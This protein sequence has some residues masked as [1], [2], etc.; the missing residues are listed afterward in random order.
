MT[1]PDAKLDPG[2]ESFTYSLNLLP[3]GSGVSKGAS[4]CNILSNTY[5]VA[6]VI[7]L[8]KPSG[9]LSIFMPVTPIQPGMKLDVQC[10]ALV[11]IWAL[12]RA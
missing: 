4:V 9:V 2:D 12:G 1:G 6:P 7:T 11:S 10:V 8:N 5:P 3:I